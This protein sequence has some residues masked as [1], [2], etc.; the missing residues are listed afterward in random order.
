MRDM[1]FSTKK[2]MRHHWTR[3]LIV[4]VCSILAFYWVM[5]LRFF[6][7]DT[8][9]GLLILTIPAVLCTAGCLFAVMYMLFVFTDARNQ[10][11]F[12]TQE[13]MLICVM[14]RYQQYPL[15]YN[16]ADMRTG[17]AVY[18]NRI[19]R[20]KKGL[21][22]II[23]SGDVMVGG[24]FAFNSETTKKKKKFRLPRNFTNEEQILNIDIDEYNRKF[25]NVN[26]DQKYYY[27][28]I[29]PSIHENLGW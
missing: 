3:G 11:Q 18:F 23:I 12:F 9:M 10:K 24:G 25:G 13:G 19:T 29:N 15:Y 1:K 20:I 8:I 7:P 28:H 27:K 6:L 14:I 21:F 22:N 16:V 17:F 2:F 4:F 5:K 26:V